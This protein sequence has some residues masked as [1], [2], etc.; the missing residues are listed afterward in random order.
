VFTK[1]GVRS[2]TQLARIELNCDTPSAEA[3]PAVV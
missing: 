3:L 1:L 2:R